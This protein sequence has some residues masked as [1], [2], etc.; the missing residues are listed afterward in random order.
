MGPVIATA[1]LYMKIGCRKSSII[2]SFQAVLFKLGHDSE[3]FD[4]STKFH[5][6]SSLTPCF[7]QA[8]PGSMV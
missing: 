5:S 1:V 2:I 4:R 3:F 7:R 6:D 8:R